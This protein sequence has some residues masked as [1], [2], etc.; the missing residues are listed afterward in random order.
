MN[1]KKLFALIG[2]ASL[3]LMIALAPA[4]AGNGA[5][6]VPN[7]IWANGVIYDT[8]VT[9]A[10]FLSPPAHSTDTLYSFDF[11]GLT[12]QRPVSDSAP[13]YGDY[14]GGRWSVKVV[15]FTE[16]GIDIHDPDGD[17]IVNFE[18]TSAEAILAHQELGHIEIMDTAI[19]FECPL[20]PAQK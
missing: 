4:Y 8:I 13:G 16:Q 7:L 11:S 10:T 12:G 6:R 20:L 3:V 14:N 17:G 2:I 1:R 5:T 19:Y 18:L 15:V 9:P